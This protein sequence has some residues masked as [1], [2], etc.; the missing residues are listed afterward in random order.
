ME[1]PVKPHYS[2]SALNLFSGN[3]DDRGEN[4]PIKY[5]LEI[6]NTPLITQEWRPTFSRM[7]AEVFVATVDHDILYVHQ[8][9][10]AVV[11]I[12]TVKILS[13]VLSVIKIQKIKVLSID[14]LYLLN[15]TL[16]KHFMK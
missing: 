16:E 15:L 5:G 14:F 7:H 1:R 10:V 2:L 9:C 8:V 3:G 12:R 13:T 6:C 11:I 4:I